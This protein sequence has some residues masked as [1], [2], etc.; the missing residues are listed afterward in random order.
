MKFKNIKFLMLACSL[1]ML[2]SACRKD[3]NDADETLESGTTF[4]GVPE[5]LEQSI[6]FTAP[7]ASG[8]VDLFS[9]KKDAA[10]NQEL[11]KSQSIVLTAIPDAITKYNEAHETEYEV[12]PVSFYTIANK[13]VTQS[14]NN[15]AFNFAP[16]DFVQKFTINLDGTK[17]TDLSKKYA[18][19]YIISNTGGLS[20][21]AASNDTIMVLFGVKNDY[22]ATYKATGG[23]TFPA[24]QSANNRTWSDREKSLT[25]ISPNVVEA[26]AGDLGGSGYWM[27]LT[28]NS[29]NTVKVTPSSRSA[30]GTIQNDGACTYDPSTKTFKLNYKYVGG[31]GD[32][33]IS[34][35]LVRQ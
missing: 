25:T 24:A 28:I 20:V 7:V 4:I 11:Q 26:E 17:W 1:T 30:N 19:A 14:S 35:E 29:D 32:R 31:T 15:L 10:N 6:F 16:G 22:D 27:Y 2:F 3:V 23:I 34:E 9:I 5:G 13:S 8:N 33:K 12:L 21:H 18:L